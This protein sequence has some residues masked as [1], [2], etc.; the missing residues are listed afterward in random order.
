MPR[1]ALLFTLLLASAA[2]AQLFSAQSKPAKPLRVPANVTATRDVEYAR[3]PTGTLLLDIYQPAKIEPKTRLPLIVWIH[4]GAWTAGDKN[5]CPAVV[6]VPRGYVVASIN[7]RLAQ[8]A[9]YP[10]Q[11]HDCKAAV[12]FLRASAE[13]Y[14][15][16]PDRVGV[17]GASAGGHLAALMG[18]SGG[19]ATLEG[20]VG[21]NADQ[22]SA[23]QAVCDW[24]GPTDLKALAVQKASDKT[25]RDLK[26]VTA[27][28]GG[29]ADTLNL[30][31]SANP[32]TF[33]D[34]KDP[35]FLIMHGEEDKLVPISQSELLHKAL[36]DAGVEVT[37]KPIPKTAH[38][39]AAFSTPDNRK[40]VAE[41][42]DKNLKPA[43]TE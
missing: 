1:L 19:D 25:G 11:I 34:K 16:D 42:F 43:K 5:L 32:I 22:S 7:Y 2:Q 33:I 29:P 40:L 4:G 9:I 31:R 26:P 14:Q 3:F 12:R 35:P 30:T 21:W 18:T 17:F 41:F 6:M 20:N 13:K 27:L 8:E 36:S 38:G 37:F 23:V 10:A 15:I 39:G 28:L 24:F